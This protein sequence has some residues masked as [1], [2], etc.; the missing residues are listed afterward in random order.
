MLRWCAVIPLSGI[1][2]MTGSRAPTSVLTVAVC[3]MFCTLIIRSAQ[4]Q[5]AGIDDRPVVGIV[6]FDLP[7][8]PLA[9]ALL[10]F[11]RV[12]ELA[13]LAPAPLLD[14]RVS[15]AVV[16]DYLPRE[17]L[18]RVLTGTGLEARFTGPDEALIVA[19]PVEL[20][21]APATASE[22]VGE[23]AI[24]G[25]GEEGEQLAYA[26]MI[27]ARLTEALC[28]LSA[29]RPGNYR[30]VAQLRLDARG[31]VAAA[32]VVTSTGLGSR[33][34]AI[35]RVMR[36]LSLDSAPPAALPEPVTILLRP[37]GNGVHVNCPQSD[38]QG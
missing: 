12:S 26:A 32:R 30:L 17:A 9:Q 18:Q 35:E 4:G 3:L 36:T 20:P 13:V 22:N 34:A 37:T 24:D 25:I 21:P 15:A 1:L 7:V 19:S 8:Q 38:Q 10:A 2:F 14:G 29:T 31:A 6:H 23:L 16:G 33:D 11:G 5:D 28:A 27:Q